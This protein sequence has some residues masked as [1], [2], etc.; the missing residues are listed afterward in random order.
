MLQKASPRG[1]FIAR[2][3][4]RVRGNM[5]AYKQRHKW[6]CKVLR[7]W[8]L[9]KNVLKL[10]QHYNCV[11]YQMSNKADTDSKPDVRLAKTKKSNVATIATARH[12]LLWSLSTCNQLWLQPNFIRTQQA[13][14][15]AIFSGSNSNSDKNNN[16]NNYI[17]NQAPISEEYSA[18][19]AGW[20]TTTTTAKPA[21]AQ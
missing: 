21:N 14:K 18:C 11:A 19:D 3:C 17:N 16:N 8:L 6:S 12:L 2:V 13:R 20:I 1:S 15:Y 9:A 5:A 7:Q 4:I 10:M